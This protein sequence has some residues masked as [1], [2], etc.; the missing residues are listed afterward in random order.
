MILSDNGPTI[1]ASS[2][3][4]G[5]SDRCSRP[6]RRLKQQGLLIWFA[7]WILSSAR[8]GRRTAIV[9]WRSPATG[10][11]G[12]GGDKFYSTNLVETIGS[13]PVSEIG[14]ARYRVYPQ[15]LAGIALVHTSPRARENQLCRAVRLLSPDAL[16]FAAVRRPW[17]PTE[18]LPGKA[19]VQ[20]DTLCRSPMHGVSLVRRSENYVRVSR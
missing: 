5:S 10:T 16:R 2:P 3:R 18:D 20:G 13:A 8:P 7:R 4:A 14:P 9:N 12:T 19:L 17:D 15:R 6:L 11:L 1:A